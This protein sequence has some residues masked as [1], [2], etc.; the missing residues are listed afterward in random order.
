[1]TIIE[2]IRSFI[3]GCPYLKDGK[4]NVDYLGAEPTE[5][6]VESVPSSGV[7]RQYTD[8]GKLRQYLFIF[9]SR[10]YYSDKVLIQLENSG[11]YENFTRWIEEQ[12]EQG[13]LPELPP[14]MK[15]QRLEVVSTGYLMDAT[16]KN[17]RYQVQCRLTYYEGGV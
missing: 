2:G 14:G 8:G 7:L 13:I 4:L 17:A 12:D 6:V 15:A 1:M 5:Y 9:G 16:E 10:E 11:F 3:C